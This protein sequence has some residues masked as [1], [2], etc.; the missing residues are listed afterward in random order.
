MTR[1]ASRSNNLPLLA[2]EAASAEITTASVTIRT[3]RVNSRQLT[4]GTFRQLPS[5]P[6]VDQ[7]TVEL[8]GTVWGWVNYDTTHQNF[9]VQFG[10][11]LCRCDFRVRDLNISNSSLWTRE[12]EEFSWDYHRNAQS[13]ILALSIHGQLQVPTEAVNDCG[14]CH[15]VIK[16]RPF[17]GS[18]AVKV[19]DGSDMPFHYDLRFIA[20]P[21]R[22]R[23]SYRW[24]DQSQRNVSYDEPIPTEEIEEA[25]R[26]HKTKLA[27]ILNRR[28][29]DASSHPIA[30]WEARLDSIARDAADYVER[31]NA[32]MA[33]LRTVKQ[34]FIAT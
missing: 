14:Q 24:D 2:V 31:W 8:L 18:H 3:L 1:T 20:N 12:L 33:R 30:W 32:L 9:V 21:P 6:F 5:R 17:F 29:V 19:P 16:K 23:R 27:E 22:T 4:M 26:Q 25:V 34:L 7:E 15:F 11:E 13:Y 28:S 10:E